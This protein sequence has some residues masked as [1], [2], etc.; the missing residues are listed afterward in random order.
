M[1]V[2]IGPTAYSFPTTTR[3]TF[4]AFT[5]A[6]VEFLKKGFQP[7]EKPQRLFTSEA[8]GKARTTS[9]F[10]SIRDL[11]RGSEK[12]AQMFLALTMTVGQFC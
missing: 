3:K 10:S 2:S 1:T 7:C 6:E 5:N 12:R 9:S 8:T 11:N 4:M